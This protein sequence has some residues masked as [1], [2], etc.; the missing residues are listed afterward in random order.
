VGAEELQ[1]RLDEDGVDAQAEVVNA[2]AHALPFEPGA[3]DAVVSV[4]A[5]HYFGTSDLYIGYIT[6]FLKPGGGLAVA[7]P[8]GR[9]VA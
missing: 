5:Y 6:Q 7:S 2:E 9:G 1:Q 3:F 4:D 8:G